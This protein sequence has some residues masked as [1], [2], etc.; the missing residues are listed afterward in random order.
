MRKSILFMMVAI[1]IPAAAQFHKGAIELSFS[2]YAGINKNKIESE[3]MQNTD[4]NRESEAHKYLTLFVRGDYFLN[5]QLSFEPEAIW[6]TEDGVYP[7]YFFSG[8]IAYH[9][10]EF[11]KQIVPFLLIGF[12]VGNAMPIVNTLLVSFENKFNVN[13][14][15]IG[16][17]IKFPLSKNVL[18]RTE[19]RY[20]QYQMKAT[21]GSYQYETYR[22]IPVKYTYYE[23][24]LLVGFSIFIR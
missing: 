19:Y 3:E 16:A 11:S 10:P 9:F 1:A 5:K 18:I 24:N 14:F 13:L 15:N 20:Q 2:G 22:Q 6:T 12:G 23:N 7:T 8:N 4:Y 17:G 21:L